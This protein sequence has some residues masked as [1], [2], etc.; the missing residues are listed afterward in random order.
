M[1]PPRPP[2][3]RHHRRL[4]GPVDDRPLQPPVEEAATQEGTTTPIPDRSGSPVAYLIGPS[5][6]SPVLTFGDIHLTSE[7]RGV[8]SFGR[9]ANRS[10]QSRPW[11]L[12]S[13]LGRLLEQWSGLRRRLDRMGVATPLMAESG[14]SA[15]AEA[16]RG[17]GLAGPSPPARGGASA[18][19]RGAR[20]GRPAGARWRSRHGAGRFWQRARGRASAASGRRGRFRVL[21]LYRELNQRSSLNFL[22]VLVQGSRA[23]FTRGL[24]PRL[25][26]SSRYCSRSCKP[27]GQF[28]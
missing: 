9:S 10:V 1:M 7:A 12:A 25:L 28:Q 18:A 2:V 16:A 24:K 20:A 19:R 8:T 17:R 23:R 13:P 11:S 6:S 4:R 14:P 15:P 26:A 22:G 21:R 3:N 27:D 5:A